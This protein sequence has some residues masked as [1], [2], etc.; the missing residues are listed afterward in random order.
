M[1]AV[2]AVPV[3]TA[4]VGTTSEDA[5]RTPEEVVGDFERL[6]GAAAV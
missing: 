1:S 6:P 3:I 4:V 5:R 2:P